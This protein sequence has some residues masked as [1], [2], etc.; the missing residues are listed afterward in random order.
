M[1]S[2]LSL[3]GAQSGARAPVVLAVAV[4]LAG[5]WLYHAVADHH[6]HLRLLRAF[7]PATAVPG[8]RHDSAWH[9]LSRPRRLLVNGMLVS[10]AVLAGLAW[11]LS[12]PVTAA[13]LVLATAAGVTRLAVRAV[14]GRPGGRAAS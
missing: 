1:M 3:H 10:A 4:V 6:G 7:R 9:A 11:E 8:T 14:H 12:P 2:A 5:S 13:C